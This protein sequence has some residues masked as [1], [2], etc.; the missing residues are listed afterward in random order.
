MKYEGKM[1]IDPMENKGKIGVEV[2]NMP[3]K[4]AFEYILRSN[5]LKYIEHPRHY[6]IVKMLDDKTT[7]DRCTSCDNASTLSPFTRISSLTRSL[8]R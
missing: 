4:K 2:N 5:L 7:K 3:W 6:E 1:I 8:G